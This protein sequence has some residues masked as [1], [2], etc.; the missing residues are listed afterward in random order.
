MF[1]VRLFRVFL[2]FGQTFVMNWHGPAAWN[3]RRNPRNPPTRVLGSIPAYNTQEDT[4]IVVARPHMLATVVATVQN[5]PVKKM[6]VT[7][8]LD[9]SRHS[10]C[11]SNKRDPPSGGSD[12]CFDFPRPPSGGRHRQQTQLPLGR[13]PDALGDGYPLH[14][15]KG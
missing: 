14:R 1:F 4:P 15:V 2:V 9:E 10:P 13:G 3:A 11:R 8:Q 7:R 6:V 12:F 5:T